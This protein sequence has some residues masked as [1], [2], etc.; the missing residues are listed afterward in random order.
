MEYVAGIA[1][2]LINDIAYWIR[3]EFKYILD[4]IPLQVVK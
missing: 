3:L 2:N 1:T 4:L